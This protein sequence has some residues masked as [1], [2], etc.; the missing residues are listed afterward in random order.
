MDARGWFIQPRITLVKSRQTVRR[1]HFTVFHRRNDQSMGSHLN[2]C[3]RISHLD[4]HI[5]IIA[6][7]LAE[8]SKAFFVLPFRGFLSAV[9]KLVL[10][11]P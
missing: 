4:C 6:L 3:S 10:T 1:R 7:A 2:A 5:C 9:G 8:Q 11:Q